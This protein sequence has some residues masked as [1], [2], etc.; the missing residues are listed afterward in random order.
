M[1]G[2]AQPQIVLQLLA[3]TLI[4]GEDPGTAVGRAALEPDP[5]GVDG[6]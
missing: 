2:D 5:R 6:L 4:A 1:G 3:R